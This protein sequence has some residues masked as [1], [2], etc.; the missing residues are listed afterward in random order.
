MRI[1]LWQYSKASTCKFPWK[2]ENV[3]QITKSRFFPYVQKKFL[4]QTVP[5]CEG[6]WIQVYPLHES[7]DKITTVPLPEKNY[8]LVDRLPAVC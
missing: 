2:L 1:F 6:V 7:R 3:K 8:V 5:D 4:V